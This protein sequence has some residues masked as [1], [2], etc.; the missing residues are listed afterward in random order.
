[1]KRHLLELAVCVVGVSTIPHASGQFCYFDSIDPPGGPLPAGMVGAYYEQQFCGAGNNTTNPEWYV[2]GTI[3]P[4]MLFLQDYVYPCG[5]LVRR[6]V[7]AGTPFQPGTFSFTVHL[8]DLD[9][10][11]GEIE[12]S[13]V[14][15]IACAPLGMDPPALPAARIDTSYAIDFTASGGTAPYTFAKTTGA[16]PAGLTLSSWGSLFGVPVASGLSTFDVRATD[17]RGCSVTRAYTL[18]VKGSGDVVAGRGFGASEPASAR[19]L[20][21][22]GTVAR[23]VNPYGLWRWGVDVASVNP[24][25]G[26]IEALLTGPG[27]GAFLPPRVRGFDRDGVPIP[28]IDF[29]A[30]AT[31]SYGVHP[32]GG[33]VAGGPADEIITGLGSGTYFAPHVRGFDATAAPLPGLSFYAYTTY[34]YGVQIAS[35]NIDLAGTSEILTAPGPAAG[36]GP[37][38]RTWRY[39]GSTVVHLAGL[40]FNAFTGGKFGARVTVGDVDGDLDDDIICTRGPG[41]TEAAQVRGFRYDGPGIAWLPGLDVTAFAT[42]YG[43]SACVGNMDA[44]GREEVIASSGPDPSAAALLNSYEYTGSSLTYESSILAFQSSAYG[45]NLAFGSYGY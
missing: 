21:P 41:S 16:L 23:T 9:P 31:T 35:G 33:D 42:T 38:I 39:T 15:A 6:A 7:V 3:P 13:Y 22:T 4:G 5:N 26:A 18:L 29:L 30:Y 19:I 11:C 32:S 43:A 28:A 20:T 8:K 44:A 24:T 2:T 17:A 12:E 27:P 25:F 14:L 40:S 1:M 45:V 34:G 37:A 10:G 36:F